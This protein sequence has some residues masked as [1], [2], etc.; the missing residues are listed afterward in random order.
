MRLRIIFVSR[1]TIDVF[2]FN[3]CFC[4]KMVVSLV[5]IK[6]NDNLI[7]N[8]IAAIDLSFCNDSQPLILKKPPKIK[9]LFNFND[10]FSDTC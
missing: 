8:N 2:F 9:E 4:S 6:T 7:I 3:V 1:L 5:C 10:T